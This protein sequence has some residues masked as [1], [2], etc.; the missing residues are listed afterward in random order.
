MK[1]ETPIRP[2]EVI[3]ELV[4]LLEAGIPSAQARQ[5][6][7]QKL[8]TLTPQA[9]MHFELVWR[10]SSKLGGPAAAA[11]NRLAEVFKEAEKSKEEVK[12]AFAAPKAT[13]QLVL[14]LPFVALGLAQAFGLNPL[15]SIFGSPLGFISVAIG[16]GLLIIGQLWTQRILARAAPLERD[17]GCLV[18]CTVIGLQAGLPLEQARAEAQAAYLVIFKQEA[19][20]EGAEAIAVA[21]SLSRSTGAALTQILSGVADRVRERDRYETS[22]RIARLSIRLMIPLGVAVLPAFILLSVV[23][24]A[25]SLLSTGQHL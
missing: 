14:G 20:V 23:P 7:A 5:L 13:A 4:S 21:G 2:A 22:S 1:S 9:S 17:L 3:S 12:L 10:L 8:P 15:G 24:I 6:M 25:I 11:L 19:E 16:L 18:D